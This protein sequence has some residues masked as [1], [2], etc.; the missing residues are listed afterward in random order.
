MADNREAQYHD[1][2]KRVGKI[3]DKLVEHQSILKELEIKQQS[4]SDSLSDIKEDTKKIPDLVSKVIIMA[5]KISDISRKT[6]EQDNDINNIRN[7]PKD[8]LWNV[9][10]KVGGII[11]TVVVGYLLGKYGIK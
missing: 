6:E 1:L 7:M 9:S 3:E 11:I 2:C 5:D 10:I 4:T 8:A